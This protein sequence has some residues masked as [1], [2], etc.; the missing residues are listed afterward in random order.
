MTGFIALKV[1]SPGR[2]G[3]KLG[4]DRLSNATQMIIHHRAKFPCIGAD[5]YTLQSDLPIL[6]GLTP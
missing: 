2:L 6:K 3:F 1:F 4:E 5:N